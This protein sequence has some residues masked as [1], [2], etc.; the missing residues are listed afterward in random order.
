MNADVRIL[1]LPYDSAENKSLLHILIQEFQE[2]GWTNFKSAVAFASQSANYPDLLD[3]MAT[4][5]ENGGNIQMTFGADVFAGNIRGTD[6]EALKTLVDK[7]T[8][9]PT[10]ELYIYREKGRTFHPKLYLFSNED[11][12]RALLIVGSSNWTRGGFINNIEAN[13]L[14]NFNLIESEH[15]E[16][17]QNLNSYFEEYWKEIS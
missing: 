8:G 4:F 2:G 10:V 6:Y 17:Y 9:F 14:V 16:C 7:L 12:S 15:Q 1:L 3:A 5:A 11:E 13:V